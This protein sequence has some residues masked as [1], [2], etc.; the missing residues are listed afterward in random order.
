MIG[1]SIRK[2]AEAHGMTCDGGF[3]YG[4]VHGL[5]VALEDGYGAKSLQIY[6][7]PPAR[8]AEYADSLEAARLT[9]LDCDAKAYRL[10]RQDPVTVESGRATVLFQDGRG[11]MARVGRYIDE[12]LP[13][14]EA[15]GAARCAY[16]GEPLDAQVSRVSL[17]GCVLPAHADCAREMTERSRQVAARPAEGSLARGAA[18]ALAGALIGAVP[19]ALVFLL[20]Y[21]TSFIGLLIGFLANLLYGKFGGR[22]S[23]ARVAVVVAAVLVGVLA[24]QAGGYTLDFL[25]SYD[26]AGGYEVT[27][28]TR[29]QFV[30]TMW[31]WILR[32]RSGRAARARV[33][34]AGRQL[35][36]GRA[37]PAADEGG[38]RRGQPDRRPL[39]RA[40]GNA[41]RIL[42]ERRH[43]RLLR[44]GRLRRRVR[45]AVSANPQAHR[46][47][48]EIARLSARLR[49][50]QRR[51]RRARA[52]FSGRFAANPPLCLQKRAFARRPRVL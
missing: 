4:V 51:F 38:I 40:G 12:V 24:G 20:G 7:C 26:P 50:P 15:P 13:R 39:L 45:A 27:G 28:L 14:L 23:R 33:R 25:R 52:F 9:L 2:Y 44:A 34:P 32:R 29:A 1:T 5:H 47:G 18:G 42:D 21:I 41:L 31:D 8:A 3:A 36:R 49:P 10:S 46:S 16:C 19:W 22:K 35:S 11:A 43:R 6:L 48:A 37:R 17:D 30:Q